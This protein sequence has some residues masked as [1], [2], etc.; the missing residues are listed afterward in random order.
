MMTNGRTEILKVSS[1]AASG[2]P[3][4]QSHSPSC[5]G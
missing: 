3:W 5:F 1:R 4:F 2:E